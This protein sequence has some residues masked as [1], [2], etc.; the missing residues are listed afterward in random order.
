[1]STSANA[2]FII[3]CS[4]HLNVDG[5]TADTIDGVL[6]DARSRTGRSFPVRV[7]GDGSWYCYQTQE[8]ADVDPDGSGAALVVERK[9]CGSASMKPEDF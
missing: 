2:T 7:H 8:D 5:L 6:R 9:V 4:G 3:T 1:M